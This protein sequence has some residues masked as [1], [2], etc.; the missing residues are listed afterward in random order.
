ME[1]SST[2]IYR[3]HPFVVI[4]TKKQQSRCLCPNQVIPGEMARIGTNISENYGKGFC[5]DLSVGVTLAET[6]VDSNTY[7]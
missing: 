6:L 7:M 3:R 5:V 1:E 2:V 4:T